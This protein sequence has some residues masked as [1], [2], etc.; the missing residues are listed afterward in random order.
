MRWLKNSNKID[1]TALVV[2]W[3]NEG[4]AEQAVFSC[5]TPSTNILSKGLLKPLLFGNY[6]LDPEILVSFSVSSWRKYYNLYKE[7]IY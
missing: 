2:H 5:I 7:E 4:K 1:V 3:V 6:L